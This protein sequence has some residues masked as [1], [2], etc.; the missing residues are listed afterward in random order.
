MIGRLI[1]VLMILVICVCV[2]TCIAESILLGLAFAKG[3]LTRQKLIQ[4]LAVYYGIET[5]SEQKPAES[6]PPLQ[7][8]VSLEEIAQQRAVHLRNIELREQMLRTLH[9]QVQ[10][11]E[12]QLAEEKRR[13]EKQREDFETKLLALR[14]EAESE[15]AAQTAAI[16]QRLKPAQAK[17]QILRMLQDNQVDQVV[18]LLSEMQESKRAKILNEFKTPE[19][20]AQLAEVL[21]RLRQ[22]DPTADLAEQTQKQIPSGTPR[23]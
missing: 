18:L 12:R 20:T 21:R 5:K 1:R 17:Q 15:G 8:H 3:K 14:K 19:E 4:M 7:E 10:S 11:Q 2:S 16:L 23:P 6:T 22:G 13:Y 9:E